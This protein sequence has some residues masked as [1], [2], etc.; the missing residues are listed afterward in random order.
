[1]GA[2]FYR[3]AVALKEFGERT[4]SNPVASLGKIVVF[5]VSCVASA[6]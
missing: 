1:M 3:G 2:K 6:G 4:G 5:I